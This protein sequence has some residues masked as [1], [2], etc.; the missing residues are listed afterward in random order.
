MQ[1]PA[2]SK[3]HYELKAKAVAS[4]R[5][6]RGHLTE[7]RKHVH[8]QRLLKRVARLLQPKSKLQ[9]P[10]HAHAG[11]R[12]VRVCLFQKRNWQLDP[13]AHKR[14]EPRLEPPP[15]K[16]WAEWHKNEL[17]VELAVW[18]R[19]GRSVYAAQYWPFGKPEVL[20]QKVLEQ[21]AHWLYLRR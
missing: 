19:Q 21:L 2:S 4:C 14:R 20:L 9:V 3:Q 13:A 15:L 16:E 8:W 5:Q 7:A 10:V 6:L 18:H 1:L 12:V 11:Q 17:K